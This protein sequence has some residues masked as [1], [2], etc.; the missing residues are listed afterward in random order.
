MFSAISSSLLQAI[1]ILPARSLD[2]ILH[3]AISERIQKLAYPFFKGGSSLYLCSTGTAE[4]VQNITKKAEDPRISVLSKQSLV[5]SNAYLN[6][7]GGL[8][9]SSGSFSLIDLLHEFGVI[10]IGSIANAVCTAG[11]VLF[12]CANI[13]ALEEN[14]R[15]YNEIENTDWAQTNIDEKELRWLKN[16]ACF[17]I[18]SNLGYLV[19]TAAL[20]FGGA[21]AITILIAVLSSLAGGIKILYELTIWF[22]NQKPE[23]SVN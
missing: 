16:A 12:L 9:I 15:L 17:G 4:I 5:P 18:V 14:V 11:S 7:H 23:G 21:T 13:F 10:N 2:I 3:S 22:H 6:L 1:E 8:M 19:A 20:L